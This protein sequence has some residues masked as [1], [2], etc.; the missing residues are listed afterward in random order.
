MFWFFFLSAF[1]VIFSIKISV[2]FCPKNVLTGALSDVFNHSQ[3]PESSDTCP[4]LVDAFTAAVSAIFGHLRK[5]PA[6]CTKPCGLSE[7]W[8]FFI[9]WSNL[10]VVSS[11]QIESYFWMWP[12]RKKT[13]RERF[14]GDHEK[15][16]HPVQSTFWSATPYLAQ[17][18]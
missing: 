7:S 8:F 18:K 15:E 9:L 10:K 13:T 16:A 2:R 4:T 14:D 11:D 1:L 3:C 5:W 6:G 17:K 12:R